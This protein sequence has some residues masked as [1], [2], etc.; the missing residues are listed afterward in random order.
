METVVLPIPEKQPSVAKRRR[1]HVFEKGNPGGPG[2]PKGGHDKF[3]REIKQAVLDAI[4]YVGEEKAGEYLAA[5][6]KANPNADLEKLKA[7]LP[8]GVS[9]YLVW[10][11][12][13][14]PVT[15]TALL[16][17]LLPIQ[18]EST[19]Q[20]EVTYRS[21]EEINNR[22]REL[23]LPVGRIYPLLEAKKIDDAEVTDAPHD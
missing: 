2:R 5:L 4:E 14:Y 23:G 12:R 15:A 8:R 11:A 3:S 6:K 7:N 9:A 21:F 10:I 19:Q 17:R 16:A 18:Q 20:V 1:G 13:N 22:L